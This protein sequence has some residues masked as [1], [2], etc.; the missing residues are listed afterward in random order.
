MLSKLCEFVGELEGGGVNKN[1][2]GPRGLSTLIDLQLCMATYAFAKVCR[3][4]REIDDFFE[5]FE[6]RMVKQ[7][8]LDVSNAEFIKHM[9][10][11]T[12]SCAEE[13]REQLNK[14]NG[15]ASNNKPDVRWREAN[16]PPDFK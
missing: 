14:T 12:I 16:E 10:S 15:E 6:E 3:N 2:L 13:L 5:A 8:M 11:A 7:D 4:D 9:H 1:E